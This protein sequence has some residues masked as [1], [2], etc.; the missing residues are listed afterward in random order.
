MIL[1]LFSGRFASCAAAKT[2]EA[3]KQVAEEKTEAA[4]TAAADVVE[5]KATEKKDA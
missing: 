5:G 3:P 1:P 4:K 2:A